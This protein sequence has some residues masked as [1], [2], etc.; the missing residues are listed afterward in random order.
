MYN[1][2]VR[3]VYADRRC[4]SDQSFIKTKSEYK[5]GFY[6]LHLDKNT[7]IRQH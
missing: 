7:F 5:N 2:S 3:N 4:L 1:D 6:L